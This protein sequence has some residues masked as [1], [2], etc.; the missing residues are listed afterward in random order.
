MAIGDV[1]EVRYFYRA[2]E[3]HCVSRLHWVETAICNSPNPALALC[4][5]QTGFWP[6]PSV[7][8]PQTVNY[9]RIAARRVFPGPGSNGETFPAEAGILP[10]AD[11]CVPSAP[12]VLLLSSDG[13]PP[14]RRGRFFWSGYREEAQFAG[15]FKALALSDYSIWLQQFT[16]QQVFESPDTSGAWRPCLYQP[17]YEGARVIR[18]VTIRPAVGSMRTRQRRRYYV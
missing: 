15:S 8:V 1:Y 9:D 16:A 7:F 13:D 18:R 11:V 5:A 3:E 4:R 2:A 17:A 10:A 6:V 14:I 12:M